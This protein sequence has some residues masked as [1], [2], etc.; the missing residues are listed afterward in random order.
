MTMTMARAL[1]EGLDVEGIEQMWSKLNR[2]SMPRR[3][4]EEVE[5][6]LFYVNPTYFL[7]K[8]RRKKKSYH[9]NQLL[10]PGFELENKGRESESQ[11]AAVSG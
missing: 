2:D 7:K 11:E 9:P 4:E 5:N 8:R 1:T 6:E 3:Q 10:L